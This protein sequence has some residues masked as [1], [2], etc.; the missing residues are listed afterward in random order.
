MLILIFLSSVT[1]R[2]HISTHSTLPSPQTSTT[3]SNHLQQHEQQAQQQVLSRPVSAYFNNNVNNSINNNTVNTHAM[4][5]FQ[6]TMPYMLSS[7]PIVSTSAT[8]L[9]PQGSLTI[10]NRQKGPIVRDPQAQQSLLINQMMA[11][12]MP[13]IFHSSEYVTNMS[14]SQ[15]MQN[16]NAIHANYHNYSPSNQANNPSVNQPYNSYHPNGYNR[17]LHKIQESHSTMNMNETTRRRSQRPQDLISMYSLDSNVQQ[18]TSMPNLASG[19]ILLSPSSS[20][21]N[22]SVHMR[23]AS[24]ATKGLSSQPGIDHSSSIK[25]IPMTIPKLQVSVF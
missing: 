22:D 2:P 10:Q 3:L 12:S 1:Y 24:A 9:V 13:N 4:S 16:V 25:L 20:S 19:Q 7:N 23:Q 18:Q 21:Y 6:T 8:N 17:E 5:S 15:S 11:P 14:S